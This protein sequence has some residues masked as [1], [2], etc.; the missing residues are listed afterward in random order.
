MNRRLTLLLTACILGS[1]F[2][3]SA[4]ADETA[5]KDQ[6]GTDN[7]NVIVWTAGEDGYHSYR[8]PSIIQAGDGSLLAFC[9]AR[10]GSLSDAGNID[11]V[12]K[13][14]KDHG[15]SWGE[16]IVLWDDDANTC[17]NP[18]PVVDQSTGKLWLLLTKNLGSDHEGDII[19]KKA[20]STRT[21]WLM[22]SA[23]NGLTWS[24]AKDITSTTKDPSWGWYATGPGVGIQI[25]HGPHAGRL[26][27]PCDHSY[28]DP[29]GNVRKGPF[30]YGAHT[31]FSDDHGATWQLGGTI[32]PHS[33]ECQIFEVADGNGK[34]VMN[35]R[36]YFGRSRRT[37]AVSHDGG[38]SFNGPVDVADLQEPVCQG[39]VI[40][41]NWPNGDRPGIL[42]FS[43][44][45]SSKSRI[46]LTVKWSF[47]DGADWKKSQLL[48]KG[49]S[50]YSCLVKLSEDK[51][52]CLYEAGSKS[53]YESIVFQSFA[54]QP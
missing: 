8:I 29:N 54:I 32:R 35:S 16:Q 17:G 3:F 53:A 2:Y 22:S 21:V 50:A 43:N 51:A 31:I 9:E 14:S 15:K 27:I 38:A 37:H 6:N 18:C 52:G 20:E 49:P 25:Q 47:N 4:T 1:L 7:A 36:A 10:K 13:R 39:S 41:F 33:N 42:L 23:N 24:D 12:L 11:I 28:D 30:G 40:R 45:A 44:P 5:A 26:V 48:H 19:H 46:D 34:L